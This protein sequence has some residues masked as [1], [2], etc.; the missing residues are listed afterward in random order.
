M[1]PHELGAAQERGP[2]QGGMMPCPLVWYQPR[3]TAQTEDDAKL[4]DAPLPL[5]RGG[6]V[7]SVV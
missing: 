4:F 5:E 2:M 6:S 1:F 3:A 7:A